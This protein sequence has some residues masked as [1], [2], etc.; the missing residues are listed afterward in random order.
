MPAI[1]WLE[2]LKG[3]DHSKDLDVES[4]IIL[5]LILGKLVERCGLNA[6]TSG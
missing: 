5:E 1:F 2:N 6:Y 4:K 3:R